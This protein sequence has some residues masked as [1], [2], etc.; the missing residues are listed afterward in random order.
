MNKLLK[1]MVVELEK[2]VMF[3]ILFEGRSLNDKKRNR[4]EK[5]ARTNW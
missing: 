3:I 5:S 2:K 4:I 1:I